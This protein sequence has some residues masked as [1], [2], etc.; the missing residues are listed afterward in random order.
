[1]LSVKTLLL[2]L[3]ILAMM[4]EVMLLFSFVLL[5]MLLVW[6]LFFF[7]FFILPVG[8]YDKETKTGGSNGATMRFSTEAKDPANAGLDI[9]RN[10]LE[11]IKQKYSGLSYGD[12]WTLA[13]VVAVEETGGPKIEWFFLEKNF[14]SKKKKVGRKRRCKG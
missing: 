3:R 11:P 6:T 13:G 8:T 1:M 9:A 2:S 5:G 14:Y 7:L 12:L 10:L 4:T